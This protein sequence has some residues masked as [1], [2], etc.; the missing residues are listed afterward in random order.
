VHAFRL[1]HD[2]NA[3]VIDVFAPDNLG[4][5]AE[6]TTS[7]TARTLSAPGGTFA[8]R[9][10]TAAPVELQ[11]LDA[12]L[13]S[14]VI[15]LP[16]LAGAIGI[17]ACAVGISGAPNDQLDDLILLLSLVDNP[18]AMC[19]EANGR[20]LAEM[21]RPLTER[22]R[23]RARDDDRSLDALGALAALTSP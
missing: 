14:G 1:G 22:I 6:L 4:S 23:A 20:K 9:T 3:V 16:S 5:R 8:L 18:R 11:L 2:D 17:K 21:L 7:G 13:V 15:R 10:A 12:Q 19:A